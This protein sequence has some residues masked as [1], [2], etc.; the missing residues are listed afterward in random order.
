MTV[1]IENI[2]DSIQRDGKGMMSRLPVK[3]FHKTVCFAKGFSL[4]LLSKRFL[5]IATLEGNIF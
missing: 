2:K 3:R 4:G 1:Y 5:N